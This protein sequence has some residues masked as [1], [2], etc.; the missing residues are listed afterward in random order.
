MK[1]VVKYL[2]LT[3]VAAVAGFLLGFRHAERTIGAGA[4][5]FAQT[6]ALSQ[7]ETLANLQY[8]EADTT[9]ATQAQL[10]LAKFMHQLEV[11]QTIAVPRAFSYERAKTLMHL[12]LL[13]EQA[14]N[15]EAFQQYLRDAQKSL[16]DVDQKWYPE[17]AM[18]KFITVADTRSKS[19][20]PECACPSRPQKAD[21]H[22]S[23]SR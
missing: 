10:D 23:V 8:Q 15:D 22:S 17:E 5:I 2:L 12:A 16:D 21:E 19:G 11:R 9:H 7:Y 6:L 20:S 4:N 13:S 18:R 3:L 1:Q 14:G